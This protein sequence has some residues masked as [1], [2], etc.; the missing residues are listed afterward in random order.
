MVA[1][2][3]TTTAAAVTPT[4]QAAPAITAPPAQVVFARAP[5]QARGDLL[6]YKLPGD[7]KIYNSATSKL[8]T[9]FSLSK[10]NVSILLAELFLLMGWNCQ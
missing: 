1:A 7:A 3:T 6:N 2:I 5:A 8:S 10:P 4:A 9:T